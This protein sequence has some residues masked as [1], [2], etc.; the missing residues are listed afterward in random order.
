MKLANVTKVVPMLL[1]LFFIGNI[2]SQTQDVIGH[3]FDI[4][5][6]D[7]LDWSQSSKGKAL[8]E[9]TPTRSTNTQSFP[10]SHIFVTNSYEFEQHVLET[11]TIDY[12]YIAYNS[13]AHYKLYD[14]CEN[15]DVLMVYTK[16]KVGT[17]TALL[18]IKTSTPDSAFVEDFNRLGR[19]ITP[20][21][22]IARYG[23]HIAQEVAYGGVFILQN[24]IA[25][26]DYIY[27]PY[28]KE[29][30]KEKVIED[31]QQQQSNSDDTDPFINAKKGRPYTV[32]GDKNQLWFTAWEASV[33]KNTQAPIEVR[34]IP[35]VD[36]LRSLAVPDIEEKSKKIELLEEATTIAI[37]SARDQ[38]S[39]KQFSTFFKKYSLRF[40]Q[41]I[42]SFVKKSMG[43]VK[44][45]G[46][47]YT[48]DIFFGGFSKD[49][50][51]LHTKPLIERG[52]LRLETLITDEVVT[53]DKNVIVTI[54]PEDI[55]YGYM[56]VWDDTKKLF[57]SKE[58]KRLRVAG[59][60]E[61]KTYYKDALLNNVQKTITLTSVDDHIYEVVYTMELVRETDLLKNTNTQYNYVIDS[62]LVAA[63]ATG[64]L[65]RLESLFLRN[66]N[67]S[68]QGL[69]E[70]VIVN[71]QPI[72]ILNYILDQGVRATTRDLD[73]LFEREN[74]NEAYALT[75]LE[76][77]AI[78][79]NNMIYKAVAYKS[80]P[81][82]YALFR[83]GAQPRNNDLSFALQLRYYPTVKALMS[84]DYDVFEA[85]M[86]QLLLAIE[87]DDNDLAK[88]FIAMGAT[89]DASMLEKAIKTDNIDLKNTIIPITEANNESLE[90]AAAI[91][92]EKLFEYFI[93][94]DAKIN[95]NVAVET[96]ID[97]ENINILDM[98]LKNGG[99]S[100]QALEYAIIKENKP[101]I[102]VAL[103]NKAKPEP[104]FA[105]AIESEDLQLFEDALLTYG[106]SYEEALTASVKGD[107]LEFAQLVLA[108]NNDTVN[109][110][111]VVP[112]AVENE[113]LEMV[114]LLVDNS[115]NPTEGIETA[116][117][118]ENIPIVQYLISEGAETMSPELITSAVKG[119]NLELSR[120][121][122]EQGNANVDDAIQAAAETA[123]VD[124]T[125][126]LLEKGATAD[127][128]LKDAMETTNEEII[129]MLMEKTTSISDNALSIACR[130]GNLSVVKYLSE[131][132]GFDI[133]K[134]VFDAIYYKQDNVLEYLLANGA[135]PSPKLLKDA[136]SVNYI[137]GIKTLITNGV[138]V[139]HIYDT[140]ETPLLICIREMVTED[141]QLIAF[142]LEK[143]ADINATN[144]VGETA[145]HLA[146]Q[147]GTAFTE[148]IKTLIGN[149]ADLTLKTLKG[150]TPLDYAS[151]R[152]IKSLLKKGMKNN[153]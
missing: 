148:V 94:K 35:I 37:Q 73:I 52:G 62:E 1:L 136:I 93:D 83:E 137:S 40:K 13:K 110:N 143:G 49:E 86:D 6:I 33:S 74:F 18:P 152:E 67:V 147:R 59:S 23:T 128:A 48:G 107:K 24:S 142:L 69:I 104:V 56:S 114:T 78:P 145:T 98:G 103:K 66:A 109:T 95:T 89:A 129:L 108:E 130:K 139:N 112:I 87:N 31:I 28:D 72:E 118:V 135:K 14:T 88:K 96:A 141:A 144:G 123:N 46:E 113:N 54:K 111:D 92:D 45:S 102:E 99:E 76:R 116:V 119:E 100:S 133:Q 29:A 20:N 134:G 64:N 32:G 26:N 60:E 30:F 9:G 97:N 15:K 11:D 16:K 68:A 105:Y 42:I 38:V 153:R 90:V 39:R 50:A 79:K 61:A 84:E 63:A 140:N 5:Y 151:D 115:A 124:I 82:V 4:R 58:R 120:V 126:Y 77:G 36:V 19:D 12:P 80:A 121:L 10:E 7:P 117:R 3:G 138:D 70:A 53:L 65:E 25:K 44:T 17:A 8:L 101:A 47:D 27:S 150:K 57:K 75:L 71:K 106:G 85:E 149:N 132:K 43:P 131:K 81:V 122:V 22:F 34:L 21:G 41:E 91:N 127:N 51:L 55:E 2:Y 125:G 146:A